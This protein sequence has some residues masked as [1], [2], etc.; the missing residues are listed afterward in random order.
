MKLNKYLLLVAA[1]TIAFTTGCNE[2]E[3]DI[4]QKGVIS[5]ENFYQTDEDA[6]S[7]MTIAYATTQKL[8]S[9]SDHKVL[10]LSYNYGPYFGLN[11]WMSDD[12]WLGGSGVG[13]CDE[14]NKL[15]Q[16]VY[17]VDDQNILC[18]YAV[19]Y[20]SILKCNYVINNF[21]SQRLGALSETQKRCVA[22]ART[23]RAYDHLL[24][25]IYWGTPPIVETILTVDDRPANSESQEAVFDWVVKECDLAIAD[26]PWRNGQSDYEGAVRITKGFALAVKGK[27]LLWKG[28]Y[29]GAK[30]ALGEVIESGNYALL[31]PDKIGAIM[32]ADGKGTSES[33]FEFNFYGENLDKD[34]EQQARGGWND[35]NT[36]TWRGE[37]LN[38]GSFNDKSIYIGGWGWINPTQDF[39]ETLID[40]DGMDSP[41][42]KAWIKT[43]D[44]ILYDLQWDSDGDNF[45]PG[46]T[47]AK[48]WDPQRGITL[49]K[50]IYG[51][52]GYF[53]YKICPHPNQG[54]QLSNNQ[55][56]RN[57]SIM[58]Y[59]EVLLMYAEACAQL[60]ETSGDGLAALNS[61]QERAGSQHISESLTLKEV[62]KEKRLELWLE[63][64][65]Y[66]DLVR[67]GKNDPSM[68]KTLEEQDRYVPTLV[69]DMDATVEGE[70]RKKTYT[71]K[72][73]HSWRVTDTIKNQE[74]DYWYKVY[75]ENLGFKEKHKLLPF[76]QRVMD[77]N[78]NIIQNPGW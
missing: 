20:S 1:G 42:R 2:D 29:Q 50:N 72:S 57:A 7:A 24:L 25:G 43:Y 65:R 78:S 38:S 74:A 56:N 13:D 8:F 28:D 18:E 30:A 52:A 69:D 51:N 53:I 4:P 55:F 36:F 71:V 68:L 45:T 9:H 70:G 17:G 19:L 40:N 14:V 67:W 46:Y 62:Q 26:L 16:F 39:A 61:I 76:P 12:F 60:G 77:L 59:A 64:C 21:T 54:D 75:N 37:N 47:E 44:E 23:L 6:E 58:R 5:T 63:G 3:L 31:P 10:P 49:D 41:R 27:A 48:A 11:N 34:E 15:H 22:E 35:H 33:V 32:H 73:P 66:A